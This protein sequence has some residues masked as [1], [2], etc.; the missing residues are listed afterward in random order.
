MISMKVPGG[1]N[2]LI[3][4]LRSLQIVVHTPMFYIVM[5]AN[6]IFFISEIIEVAMF[7]LLAASWTTDYIF[8]YGE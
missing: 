8:V 4:F 3:I 7:D 1:L 5:P 6:V 2:S